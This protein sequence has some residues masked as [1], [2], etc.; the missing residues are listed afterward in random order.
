LVREGSLDAAC[1][2]LYWAPQWG[3]GE[4]WG[5]SWGGADVCLVRDEEGRFEHLRVDLTAR[6]SRPIAARAGSAAAVL[7]QL[8]RL[9]PSR[10]DVTVGG[11]DRVAQRLI[12]T[13]EAPR[14]FLPTVEKIRVLRG[15]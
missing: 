15:N 4:R 6:D 7:S 11:R 10:I 8:G 9:N 1:H 3:G 13:L 14:R 12:H 2:W 5:A